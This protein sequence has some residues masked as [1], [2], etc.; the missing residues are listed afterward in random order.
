MAELDNYFLKNNSWSFTK[1]RVWNRCRRQY[2]FDYIAPYL[3]TPAPVDVN[4]IRLLKNYHSRFVLQG[5]IIHDILDE[6]IGLFCNKKPMDPAGAV[7]HY[8]KKVAQN[9]MMA[10]ELFTEY[11]HGE[12]VDEQFFNAIEKSG[13]ACLDTFFGTIWPKYQDREPLR[14]EEY[15]R[16]S[17]GDVDVL[18]KVDFASRTQ[19]GTIVLTDWKTGTDN[20]E[21]ETELQMAAYALWATQY[22]NKSPDEIKSEL[23][24]LKTGETKPYPFF[25]EQLCEIQETITTDFEAMNISYEY[26]DFPPRPVLRECLSCR[27]AEVCSEARVEC[28]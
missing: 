17:M 5:Q 19:N 14:H 8:C 13:K 16:F 26:E 20:D 28:F 21:Y 27:F 25:E 22:Y 7:S 4:K 23:V 9:K 2:Y 15:D 11:R 10:D 24:F 12:K 1:H 3:K 18:V 6:Q